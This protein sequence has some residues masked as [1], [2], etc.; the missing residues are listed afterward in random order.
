MVKKLALLSVLLGL[1]CAALARQPFEGP[2]IGVGVGSSSSDVMKNFYATN[3]KVDTSVPG[4]KVYG[5]YSAGLWAIEVGAYNFG[6]FEGN[7]ATDADQFKTTAL[8]VSAVGH[9]SLV[10]DV[11]LTGKLGMATAQTKYHCVRNCAGYPDQTADSVAP[12]LGFG[13][14]WDV[15]RQVGLRLDL[16]RLGKTKAAAGAVYAKYPYSLV[17]LGAEL[18]F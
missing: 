10:D 1:S 12:L 5:G 7:T 14:R 4:A 17:S 13:L 15:T 6:T 18:H 9:F 3:S 11:F 8:A 16:E 2:Y